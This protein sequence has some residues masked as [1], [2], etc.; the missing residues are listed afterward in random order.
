MHN[1]RTRSCYQRTYIL[2]TYE[3]MS[4]PLNHSQPGIIPDSLLESF[5]LTSRM[6][7]IAMH[8]ISYPNR[9]SHILLG[10][11]YF[12]V[13]F[14]FLMSLTVTDYLEWW[15]QLVSANSSGLGKPMKLNSDCNSVFVCNVYIYITACTYATRM[16]MPTIIV[17]ENILIIKSIRYIFAFLLKF[18]G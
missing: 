17:M 6:L 9:Y 16:M 14:I 2:E 3:T 18:Y 13:C 7:A 8:E 5:S 15:F 4:Q 11:G 10:F 12:S 1:L